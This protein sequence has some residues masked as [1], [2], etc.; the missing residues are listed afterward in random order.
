[1]VALLGPSNFE[2]LITIFALSRLGYSVLLLSNRLAVIAYEFLVEKTNSEWIVY[3]S[4]F[5]ATVAL[6][7][8]T[9]SIGAVPMLTK[10]DFGT[11]RSNSP[12]IHTA[13]DRETYTH[14]TSFI[15]HS[16]GSTGLPKPIFQTHAACLK[17]YSLGSG[18]VAF[19]TLPLYH[20]FGI[21]NA[22]RSMFKHKEIY[23]HNANVPQTG[24][25]L[26]EI[27]ECAK[28]GIIAAVPYTYKLLGETQRGVNALKS[29][30]I[31]MSGGSA[32]PDDLGNRLVKHGVN[33]IVQ[34]GS[35]VSL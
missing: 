32:C 30:D 2:Y 13:I 22:Y 31:V 19:T 25:G 18:K 8:R 9:R 16:S 11:H 23:F 20:N 10:A 14:K 6:L 35:Y 27:I 7:N 12:F 28:P 34:F 24:Q 26:A 29:C 4:R 5:A 1:M 15:I 21:A 3:S 33:L 17:S